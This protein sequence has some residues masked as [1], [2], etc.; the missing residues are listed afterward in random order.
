MA[1]DPGTY[2]KFGSARTRP[3]AELLARVEAETP[4]VVTDLGCGP[5][6]STALLAARWPQAHIEGVD[7][8][9]VMLEE[10]RRAKVHAQWVEADI[11][12][13]EPSIPCDVIFSNAALHWVPDHA[14][15]LP[16]LMG[17]LAEGGTLAFQVP[18]NFDEPSHRIIREVA[19]G[20]PW[21]KTLAGLGDWS[22]VRT[23][24]DYYAVLE[25][26]HIDVWETIYLQ[27]LEGDDAVFRWV[28]GTALLPFAEALE[29]PARAAFLEECRRRMANAY[30]RRTSGRTLF[31]FRRLF[32][33][34]KL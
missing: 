14:R 7:S 25:P 30:P 29:E 5:G 18:R 21:A 19:E 26:A 12:R 28:S 1:W 27:A 2:L 31:S 32:V 24:R 33:V 34:A 16:R 20:G 13:W 3:A 23:P 15:L 6:N 4:R 10:A 17:F 11:A 22:N 9:A 8:S